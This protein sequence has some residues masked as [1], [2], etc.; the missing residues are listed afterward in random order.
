MVK[1]AYEGK[2][3]YCSCVQGTEINDNNNVGIPTLYAKALGILEFQTIY[4]S[5]VLRL[6][7]ISKIMI[8]PVSSD[9]YE[10]LVRQKHFTV[11]NIIII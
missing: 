9:D 2:E 8:S 11:N 5:D 3:W 10:I 1:L 4:L 7:I 6:P